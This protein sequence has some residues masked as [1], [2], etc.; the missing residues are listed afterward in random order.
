MRPDA[1]GK[2]PYSSAADCAIKTLKTS[3]PLQFYSGFSTYIVR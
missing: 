3:G 1:E 2:V